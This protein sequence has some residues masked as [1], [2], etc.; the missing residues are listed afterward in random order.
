MTVPAPSHLTIA[1]GQINPFVGDLDGNAKKAR[2]AL[3]EQ[4]GKTLFERRNQGVT[5]TAA[6]RP[7]TR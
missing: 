3:E 1:V 7:S 4:L 2:K 5:L 6:R